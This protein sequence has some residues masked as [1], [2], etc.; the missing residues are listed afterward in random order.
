MN[1]SGSGLSL[2]QRTKWG[3][4]GTRGFS[5][6]TGIPGL[7]YRKRYRKKEGDSTGIVILLAALVFPLVW[8]L[9]Q[10]SLL[11]VFIILRIVLFCFAYLLT[12]LWEV[13]K[14]C[15]LTSWDFSM[16]C[17]EQRRLRRQR[18]AV[19]DSVLAVEVP[20]DEQQSSESQEKPAG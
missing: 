1:L 5:I 11:V 18:L 19:A 12:G 2:T 9:I 7:Y 3:S 8:A 20:P 14:W 6:R 15:A 10:A 4:W 17:F 16:Y 13:T